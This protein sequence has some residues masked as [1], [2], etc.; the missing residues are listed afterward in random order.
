MTR[1]DLLKLLGG[2][3]TGT[4]TPDER[5][6]LYEAA[7]DD[8]ALFNALADEQALKEML[9]DPECRA[10]LLAAAST[11][12]VFASAPKRTRPRW[13]IP[14]GI[15]ASLLV[16]G[17]TILIVQRQ[18]ER[19]EVAGLRERITPAEPVLEPAQPPSAPPPPKARTMANGGSEHAE[20]R[21]ESP[22]LSAP[23]PERS[24][25]QVAV[26][27]GALSGAAGGVIGGVVGGVPPGA[28]IGNLTGIAPAAAPIP[29]PPFTQTAVSPDGQVSLRYAVLRRTADG[30]YLP[31]DLKTEFTAGDEIR[32]RVQASQPGS[33][34]VGEPDRILFVSSISPAVPVTTSTLPLDAGKP[35]EIAFHRLVPKDAPRAVLGFSTA[36]RAAPAVS[37]ERKAAEPMADKAERVGPPAFRITVP[38]NI[39]K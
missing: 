24:T 15:A 21:R 14:L 6:I 36:K 9:D 29:I 19:T 12:A 25:R 38:L 2:Y 13:L 35:L 32:L 10:R 37:E 7:L 17:S 31:V 3:A 4:L 16:I 33:V 26:D 30:E 8:Q 28:A 22:R 20:L 11:E 27:T 23:I 39:K 34:T 18:P 1:D 5:N